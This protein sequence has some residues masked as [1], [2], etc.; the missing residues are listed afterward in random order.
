MNE[1]P[2]YDPETFHP[3]ITH[4]VYVTLDGSLLRLAYPRANIPRWAAFDEALHEAAFLHSCTYQLANSKVSVLQ[5]DTSNLLVHGEKMTS[6]LTF[7]SLHPLCHQ[8]RRWK[9]W[10]LVH[11]MKLTPRLHWGSLKGYVRAA[12]SI[13]WNAR[14]WVSVSLLF[15]YIMCF[16]FCCLWSCMQTNKFLIVKLGQ[17]MMPDFLSLYHLWFLRS[18]Y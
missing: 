13:W 2:T 11:R 1:A 12:G 17:K 3:S 16:S 5:K 14:S 4:S 10:A 9:S 18:K 8:T 6:L 7:V 15:Y